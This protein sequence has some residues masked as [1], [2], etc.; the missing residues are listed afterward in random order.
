MF[1]R[2]APGRAIRDP[3]SH[4]LLNEAGEEKPDTRFWRRRVRDKDV[5]V[6]AAES[7]ALEQT[8]VA[9]PA[10]SDAVPAATPAQASGEH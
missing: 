3:I 8:V 10:P 9:D 2:P 4:K 6:G 5:L 1:V 7:S